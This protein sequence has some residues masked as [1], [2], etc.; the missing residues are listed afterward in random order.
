MPESNTESVDE[1]NPIL[2]TCNLKSRNLSRLEQL[3]S[4]RV[5]TQI[6]LLGLHVCPFD[7]LATL[8]KQRYCQLNL[9]SRDI[10]PIPPIL[11]LQLQNV[12]ARAHVHTHTHPLSRMDNLTKKVAY[13]LLTF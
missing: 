8:L 5:R 6:N 12:C 4:V 1:Y 9:R 13:Y 11:T 3:E 7:H 2:H 10:Q